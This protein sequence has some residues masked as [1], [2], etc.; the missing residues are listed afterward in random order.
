MIANVQQTDTVQQF[1]A[2]EKCY[3]IT[4][5]YNNCVA[6]HEPLSYTDKYPLTKNSWV[7]AQRRA[8]GRDRARAG[9]KVAQALSRATSCGL[10]RPASAYLGPAVAREPVRICAGDA[11]AAGVRA[12]TPQAHD[13]S[14]YGGVFRSR[15]FGA[16][17]LNADVGLFLN[18]P[19]AV[20]VDPQDSVHLLMGTDLGLYSSHNG[21]RSWT[22][23]ARDHIIGAGLRGG[24]P[25]RAAGSAL[26]RTRAASSASKRTGGRRCAFPAAALPGQLCLAPVAG[27]QA[28]SSRRA[29]GFSGATTAG[30]ASRLRDSVTGGDHGARRHRRRPARP[31]G[32]DRRHRDGERRRR[33]SVAAD[34]F[35]SRHEPV[36]VIAARRRRC[37]SASGAAHADRIYS[38]RRPGRHMGSGGPRPAGARHEGARHRGRRDRQRRW[39]SQRIGARIAAA[40]ADGAG[41]FRRATF[42][43]HLEA[44]PLARDPSD[45]QRHFTSSYSLVPLC[46]GLARGPRGRHPDGSALDPVSLAG[47]AAFVLLLCRGRLA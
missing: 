11:A 29:T 46:R 42:P 31:A 15:D 30:G 23:E 26:R 9:R 41:L 21:G 27:Q 22:F 24:L 47:A 3:K 1:L 38:Q 18:A 43:V 35:G 33:P 45:A 17:W 7:A 6:A 16:T 2:Y 37:R 28:L 39:S 19:L 34:R 20:A 36:D 8:D 44:G 12:A 13:A 4:G 14:S 25:A 10:D 40:M 32:G 5:G